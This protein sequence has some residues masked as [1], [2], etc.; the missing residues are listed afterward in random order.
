MV[1]VVAQN[2]IKADKI[3]AFIALAKELVEATRAND[4]GCIYYELLQDLKDPQVITILE[5][6]ES[7]E[8]LDAHSQKDHF[9]KAVSA[10]PEY[11]EKPGQA[12]FYKTII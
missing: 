11:M 8:D 3:D 10:F 6:W 4:K 12:H 9:K 5:H 1:K 2:Y 7:Q